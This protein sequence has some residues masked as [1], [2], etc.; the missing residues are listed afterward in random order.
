MDR[1]WQWLAAGWNDM[2]TAPGIALWYGFIVAVVMTAVTLLLQSIEAYHLA[3]GTMAGFVFIGPIL[4][5]GLYEVSRRLELNLKVILPNT[6]HGW[7]RNTGSLLTVGVVLMLLLLSWFMLSMQ[8]AAVLYSASDELILLFGGAENLAQF[9]LSIRWPMV[10][11]FVLS[12]L[13]GMFAVFLLTAVSL[14]LLT[15]QEDMDA[16]TA[17]VTSVKAVAVN[18]RAMLLWAGLIALFTAVAVAP[19]FLGLIVLFPLLAFASWHA[20][21]DLIAP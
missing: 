3:L 10:V 19:L 17:M 4:A 16:I 5:V 8:L 21:R 6:W 12:G 13:V 20:Y 9:A 11:A 15:D 7:R 1:P 14:P 18:W 2:A